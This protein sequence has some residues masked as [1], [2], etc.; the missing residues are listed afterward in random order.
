MVM[1]ITSNAPTTWPGLAILEA[2]P[3]ALNEL[4]AQT[5]R[6]PKA[7]VSGKLTAALARRSIATV[8]AYVSGRD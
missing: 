3:A 8:H 7:S 2:D 1:A 5:L 4:A 6:Y